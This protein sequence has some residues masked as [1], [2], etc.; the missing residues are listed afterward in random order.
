MLDVT[1]GC[2]PVGAAVPQEVVAM[3]WTV[4]A[5]WS[6]VMILLVAMVVVVEVVWT[7]LFMAEEGE[8]GQSS[9]KYWG[10]IIIHVQLL[11][12]LPSNCA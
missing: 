11:S 5:E 7:A 3:V 1:A 2:S 9:A 4:V 8:R 12:L 10:K 6:L